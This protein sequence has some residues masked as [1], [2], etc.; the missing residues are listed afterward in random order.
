M[1]VSSTSSLQDLKLIGLDA[2]RSHAISG[3]LVRIV[4]RLS[5]PPPLGW[6]Y[7]FT[8]TWQ[9]VVYP[10]KRATGVDGDT[11]WIDCLAEEVEAYHLEQIKSAVE[12]T[13]KQYREGALLQAIHASHQREAD[14]QLRSKLHDMS[15]TLYPTEASVATP[16]RDPGGGFLGRLWRFLSPRKRRKTHA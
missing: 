6:S 4:F 3:G 5:G 2:E 7:V 15:R 1:H 10:M 12:Q 13:N 16:P 11:I 14:A 9:T 8:T